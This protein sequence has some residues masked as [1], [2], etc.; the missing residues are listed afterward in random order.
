MIPVRSYLR[1]LS[2][3][4]RPLRARVVLLS[5]V[6]LTGIAFQVVNPQLIRAFIDRV[7]EGA[8][9]TD[10]IAL[11]AVLSTDPMQTHVRPFEST[12]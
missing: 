7:T 4:L 9:L 6:L 5:A 1:L 12:K 10:L 3:Y 8:D 11:A 2:R